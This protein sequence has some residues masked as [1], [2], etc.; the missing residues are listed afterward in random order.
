MNV[1]EHLP[2]SSFRFLDPVFLKY[3]ILPSI[4]LIFIAILSLNLDLWQSSDVHHFYF[5]M[6]AVLLSSILAFY[7]MARAYS[8]TDT[9]SLFIGIGFLT[10]AF[11]DLLHGVLSYYSAGNTLFLQYFIPQT[12]FAGRTFIG[13]MIVIAIIKYAKPPEIDSNASKLFKSGLDTHGTNK[14]SPETVAPNPILDKD[15]K[16]NGSKKLRRPLVISLATLA[17]LAIAVATVSFFTVFPGVVIKDYFLRRPYEIPSLILFSVALI[18]FYT[19]RLYLT[20]DIFFKGLLGALIIDVFSQLVMSY[21]AT[22]FDTPHNVSHVLKNASYFIII[23]GLA[24]SGIQYNIELRNSNNR[25][26]ER[27]EV[28]RTQY[29][30]LKE[31]DKMQK[32]FINI[33]AHELRTPIQP[34][35]G[36]SDIMLS[37]TMEGTVGRNMAEIIFR[38]ARRL[39]KMAEDILDVTRIESRTLNLRKERFDLNEVLQNAISDFENRIRTESKEKRR[40]IKIRYNVKEQSNSDHHL[41]VEADKTRILQVLLNLL[42]NAYVSIINT[43]GNEAKCINVDRAKDEKKEQHNPNQAKRE[44]VAVISICDDGKGIE[45]KILSKLFTKFNSDRYGGMGL[46]LYISKSI[47]EAHGGKIWAQNNEGGSGATFSFSIPLT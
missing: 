27:E 7:C 13:A 19:K 37:R 40:T 3:T 46:G 45:A 5:E 12:W 25:L 42:N 44:E 47:I 35:L 24:L 41:M 38:N 34:I 17:L 30:K 26:K 28:I 22:A 21:S 33:A 11:I 16:R 18:L 20:Q 43:E 29:E 8:L 1:K 15:F 31:S 14:M 39:N 6:V 9:F 10:S 23:V 36:L 4:P 2:S 32:E